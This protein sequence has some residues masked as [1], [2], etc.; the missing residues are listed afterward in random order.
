MLQ[1]NLYQSLRHRCHWEENFNLWPNDIS[2]GFQKRLEF[3]EWARLQLSDFS[4]NRWVAV[5]SGMPIQT[6]VKLISSSQMHHV[7]P[8]GLWLAR[9]E[10]CRCIKGKPVSQNFSSPLVPPGLQYG[11]CVNKS[12]SDNKGGLVIV[13]KDAAVNWTDKLQSNMS[14]KQWANCAAGLP[15]FCGWRT[16]GRQSLHLLR[17]LRR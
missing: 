10:P 2:G 3:K 4:E 16:K 8:W 11:G 17:R 13:I 12:S 5:G 14:R 6:W 7:K 9:A 1:A 15:A